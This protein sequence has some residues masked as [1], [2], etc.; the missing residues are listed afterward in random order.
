MA[1]HE[2]GGPGTLEL[3]DLTE[4][5]E[6]KDPEKQQGKKTHA[7]GIPHQPGLWKPCPLEE[8]LSPQLS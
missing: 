2:V 4:D 5:R 6:G 8:D 7:V 3:K 1:Q